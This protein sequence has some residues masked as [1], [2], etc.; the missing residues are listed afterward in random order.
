MK[1]NLLLVLSLIV[2]LTL[3]TVASYLYFSNFSK[4]L[5]ISQTDLPRRFSR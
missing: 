2:L 3:G 1:K 5:P 4:R